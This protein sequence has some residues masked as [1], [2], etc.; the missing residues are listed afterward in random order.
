V[1]GG[2]TNLFSEWE[3]FMVSDHTKTIIF[4]NNPF[5]R[6]FMTD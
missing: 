5:K 4:S 2:E 6:K 3:G 1:A